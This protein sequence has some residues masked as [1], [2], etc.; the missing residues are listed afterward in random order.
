M[1]MIWGKGHGKRETD[2]L[3]ARMHGETA[4][5]LVK[6]RSYGLRRRDAIKV[7]EGEFSYQL[8]TL[9]SEI[10]AAEPAPRSR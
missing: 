3:A 5:V 9:L 6:T 4:A 8:A 1:S 7:T 10:C 2:W